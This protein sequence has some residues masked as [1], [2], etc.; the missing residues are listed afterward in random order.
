M[1]DELRDPRKQLAAL[2]LSDSEISLYLAMNA[3]ARTAQDCM[4]VT[5]LKRPTVY[6][7]LGCL[8]KRGLIGKSGTEG[9]KRFTLAP[10]ERLVAIAQERA[11]EASRIE[12]STALLAA[13]LTQDR[14]PASN[15]P[16]VAFFEGV[17]A[18]KSA[19]M[20]SLYC[21]GKEIYSI[22]P[23]KN[24]FWEVGRDFVE[25]FVDER[26][27]RKIHTKNLWER[28]IDARTVHDYYE[29]FSEIRIVPP[30]MRNNFTSTI[31]LYDDK[32]LVVSSM[33]NAYCILI[34]SQEHH[35]TVRALFDGL[36]SASTPHP[37]T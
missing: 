2:G 31:F 24:F 10:T 30:A 7:A 14:A 12:E 3:G 25:L 22:A 1:A 19:V 8:E 13:T 20:E 26:R 35:D 17:D 37:A 32:T 15:K 33:K 4:K 6:Y 28:S 29:G 23:Q 16:S 27:R 5:R 9:E 11:L 21:K 36:W 34:T 18:V